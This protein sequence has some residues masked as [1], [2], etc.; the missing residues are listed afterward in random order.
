MFS[1]LLPALIALTFPLISMSAESDPIDAPALMK[2]VAEGH[3]PL[4]LDTRTEAEFAAGH[5]PGA[6][7]VP[8]DRLDGYMDDLTPARDREIVLYCRSGRRSGLVEDQLR[9]AGFTHLRQLDGSW[10][11]WQAASLPID[12]SASPS[13]GCMTRSTENC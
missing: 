7:L 1:R 13:L 2:R 4:I 9:A 12:L 8:H 11:A 6:V 10:Q 5:V 3:A